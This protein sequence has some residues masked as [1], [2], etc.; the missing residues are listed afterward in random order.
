MRPS[1]SAQSVKITKR[2]LFYWI[3]RRHR[4]LQG[5]LLVIIAASLFF[6]VFPLE[7][8]K[9]IINQAI[10]LKKI[11]LLYLYC[12]LYMGSVLLAGLSK[13]AINTLQTLIGQKILVEMRQELY[14]HILQLPLQFYRK[15]QPGTVVSAMT[16]ELNAIGLFLGGALTIPLTSILSFAVFLGFMFHLSPL[17]AVLSVTIYPFELI[18]IPLLQK[19]YN[20][21]NRKRI[22]TTRA[23]SN[24]VNEAISGL[25]E[26]HANGSY[27]LEE[28]RM[29]KLVHNLYRQLN[30]LFIVKYGIK[31]ANNLFQSIGPFIL[32]LVGGYLAIHGQFTLGALVAFL[33][34]YEKVYDP[35]KEMLEYYQSYQD[36]RVRYS[37]IMSIFDHE[38]EHPMLP[39]GRAP[40]DFSGRIE[41]KNAGFSVESGL[42]L[43]NDISLAIKANEQV[44]L[45][46]FS[47]S[48]KS[49]LALLIAQLYSV[50]HG[51]IL[52]DDLDITTLSKSDISKNITMI[53]QRPFI[54]TGTI[55]E[56]LLYGAQA[57][58]SEGEP[59]PE[60]RQLLEAVRDV[61]LSEDIVRFGLNTVIPEE[62]V[63]PLRNQLL[64]M[65]QI[66]NAELR[67]SFSKV[68]E[69][70]DINTFLTYS[71]L[72]DNLIFGESLNH[73]Y[74]IERLAANQPYRRFLSEHQLEQ[75]LLEL[76]F[77][78][79]QA[80]VEMLRDLG[81]DDF[82]FQGSPMEPADLEG[83]QE[84][85]IAAKD[86][87]PQKKGDQNRLLELA[88]RYI[89]ARHK[90]TSISQ[91]LKDAI[92]AARHAFLRDII[93]LDME[94]CVQST[95]SL[96]E[97]GT[98]I[99]LPHYEQL[100][101][102]IAYCPSEYLYSHSLRDNILFGAP[103]GQLRDH[104]HLLDLAT[105][106]FEREGLLDE[107]LDIGLDFEVGSQGDRLSGGQ[108][109]KLAIAR[110]F[111]KQSN[112]LILDEATA[113]LDNT[114]QARIQRILEER[115]RNKKTIISV[116]HRLDLTPGYD[117]IFVLKA[118]SLIEQGTYEELMNLRGA[119]YELTQAH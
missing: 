26:I 66:I 31:F 44:A 69:P 6:R 39:E 97:Q 34:A 101:D 62:R 112:L 30:G 106:A 46:G 38:I 59:V 77:R 117:R 115:F 113:S 1:S 54:F 18:V 74:A 71:S 100:R 29:A 96:M 14:H 73:S 22:L 99:P 91:D 19:R 11:E 104:Q 103:K 42:K 80:T 114:S 49:T 93:G 111:L 27:H 109:Q 37:Q 63:A 68:V 107:I 55:R 40:L 50:N 61:G 87:V 21:Y 86:A 65:R 16:A 92:L 15:M 57:G 118:G 116:I 81:D 25:H 47:G 105:Q 10:S 7:M 88:F 108:K 32:F 8:Q 12:G 110:A 9:R 85:L 102:F 23:M 20:H 45:V 41:L 82:F 13:Y 83:Y 89:P 78:I 79:A 94:A 58:E 75:P 72:R 64:R 84:L 5:V 119:F 33:S 53:A 43:L 36:S 98:I 48:G 56:N 3:L 24:V 35:W 52:L 95:R 17:L 90:I 70:Y 2:P 51:L 76:G 4:S 28:R 67:E 60:R